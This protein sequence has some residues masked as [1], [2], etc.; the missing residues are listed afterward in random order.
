MQARQSAAIGFL[1]ARNLFRLWNKDSIQRL[2]QIRRHH[3]NSGGIKMIKRIF[4]ISVFILTL[5]AAP[6]M[7]MQGHDMK[8]DEQMDHSAHDKQMDHSG[9]GGTFKHAATEGGVDA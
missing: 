5:I 7:A 4:L 6:A 1:N 8:S 9:M 3:F 2:S